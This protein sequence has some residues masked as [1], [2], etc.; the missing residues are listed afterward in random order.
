MLLPRIFTAIVGIPLILIGIH[1]GGIP[2]IVLTGGVAL[3]C[4]S[5]LFYLFESAGY[6]CR[7]L[8]GY[9]LGF[10]LF[11]VF[12]FPYADEPLR[13]GNQNFQISYMLG[14]S[15]TA[16]IILV[17]VTEL[18]YIQTRSL[19]H[20][21]VTLFAVLL[22][23]W[24]L[25]HIV[26][27][28]EVLGKEWCYYLFITIW[29]NDSF[30]Y[31]VGKSVGKNLL[32]PRLS[33]KKTLEGCVGGLIGA[34]AAASILWLVFFRNLGFFYWQ[35]AILGGLALGAMGQISDVVES[36]IKREAR[37]KDSSNILPGHGGMLDRFDSFILAAPFFYYC[38]FLF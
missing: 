14:F 24:P 7:K 38:R 21:A 1:T 6:P 5:E 18:F 3:L 33:P 19:V 8:V 30:S 12:I 17:T 15:V 2:L 28:R 27:I 20:S 35:T 36:A 37:V 9:P 29:A 32:A 31:I 34:V 23:T 11:L 13:S 26:V 16:A 10:L 22:A 4:L 25:A